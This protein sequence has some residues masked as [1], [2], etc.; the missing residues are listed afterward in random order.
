MSFSAIPS[1]I[2]SSSSRGQPALRRGVTRRIRRWHNGAQCECFKGRMLTTA[3]QHVTT[4]M[5]QQRSYAANSYRPR[6]TVKAAVRDNQ[7]A[8]G[9]ARSD[10]RNSL[11]QRVGCAISRNP[12]HKPA[13]FVSK[14]IRLREAGLMREIVARRLSRSVDL[15]DFKRC[16]SAME[17]VGCRA[18]H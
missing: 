7:G 9:S 15:A 11:S 4:A 16:F 13:I 14:S 17:E 6:E 10:R 12:S 8:V 2:V 1:N 3:S 18:G 5:C